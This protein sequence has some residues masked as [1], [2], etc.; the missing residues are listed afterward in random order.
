MPRLSPQSLRLP[1]IVNVKPTVAWG[2]QSLKVSMCLVRCPDRAWRL[3]NSASVSRLDLEIPSPESGDLLDSRD[4]FLCQVHGT[5]DVI[6]SGL[7]EPV[8]ASS[9]RRTARRVLSTVSK[10]QFLIFRTAP[11]LI[12][13]CSFCSSTSSLSLDKS[14]DLRSSVGSS[15]YGFISLIAR[16]A[17]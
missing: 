9:R 14:P 16:F 17:N 11:H 2:N 1:T 12:H 15:R 10:S 8:G 3:P 5:P 6:T 4:R 7:V 13:S